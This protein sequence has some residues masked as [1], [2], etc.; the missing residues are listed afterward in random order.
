MGANNSQT[1]L[2]KIVR[3]L[4]YD[5]TAFAHEVIE[6]SDPTTYS[7]NV[8]EG[9]KYAL[10]YLTGPTKTN[11]ISYWLDG[12]EPTITEG[13]KRYAETAFD[14]NGADDIKNFKCVSNGTDLTLNIQ[15]YR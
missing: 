10:L 12:G 7:L 11:Y 6:L 1:N 15:Y 5:A 14:I 9:T 3:A 8:P 4:T 13:I 2:E